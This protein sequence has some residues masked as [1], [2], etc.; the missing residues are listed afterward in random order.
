MPSRIAWSGSTQI[1][2]N[3]IGIQCTFASPVPSGTTL[4]TYIQG[5]NFNHPNDYQDLGTTL[6][7]AVDPSEDFALITTADA[8]ELL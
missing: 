6:S 3:T 2:L 7:V 1:Y 4:T 5:A 8:T